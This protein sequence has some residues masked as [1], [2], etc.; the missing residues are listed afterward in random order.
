M[1]LPATQ[2]QNL[3]MIFNSMPPVTV[4]QEQADCDLAQWKVGRTVRMILAGCEEG[5]CID[6]P[7]QLFDDIDALMP[8]LDDGMK[9]Q[10]AILQRM[11]IHVSMHR[12]GAAK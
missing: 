8:D 4:T 7:E 10:A 9:V 5:D 6:N 12:A 3:A 1:T 11:C 2:T